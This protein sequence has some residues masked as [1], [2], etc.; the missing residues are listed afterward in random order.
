MAIA[1]EMV[2]VM[3]FEIVVLILFTITF[4]M[5]RCTEMSRVVFGINCELFV[6]GDDN[7]GFD[8]DGD[9][10]YVIIIIIS[11]SIILPLISL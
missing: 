8:D 5:V 4:L 1:I 6:V 11:S 3:P 2:I 10:D 7:D 9:D